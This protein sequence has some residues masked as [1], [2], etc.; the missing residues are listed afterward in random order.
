MELWLIWLIIAGILIVVE[1]LTLTFYLLW[2]GIGAVAA[3]I[4]DF[5]FPDALVLEVIVG[6]VVALILTVFTK[7]LT[8]RVRSSR[9]FKD[10]V[11]ELV[12]KSGIVLEDVSIDAPGIVKIGNETWSALSNEPIHKGESIVVV[13]RGSAVLQVKRWGGSN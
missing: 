4:I 6:C 1:M 13:S 7:T 2:L 12:G 8:R 10:A 11:D 3:A 5:I 9:G